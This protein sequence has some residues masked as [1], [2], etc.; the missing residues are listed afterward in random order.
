MQR[1]NRKLNLYNNPNIRFRETCSNDL[2]DNLMRSLGFSFSFC[3]CFVFWMQEN[4]TK[5]IIQTY[6]YPPLSV[7]TSVFQSCAMPLPQRY[8]FYIAP[9]ECEGKLIQQAREYEIVSSR[10]VLF[11]CFSMFSF[12]RADIT[13]SF[14]VHQY[15]TVSPRDVQISPC[16][17]YQAQK[18]IRSF[19]VREFKIVSPRDVLLIDCSMFS[20]QARKLCILPY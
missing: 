7:H 18:I 11:I 9:E 3:F 2:L 6:N 10:D 16:V 5:K 4:I 8:D 15:K 19:L 1:E 17:S 20:Y 12:S 14:L 13:Y